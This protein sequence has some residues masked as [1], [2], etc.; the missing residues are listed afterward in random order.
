MAKQ[1]V[2]CVKHRVV[3][4][5]AILVI[6]VIIV[7]GIAIMSKWSEPFDT[8]WLVLFIV[9][10]LIGI[11]LTFVHMLLLSNEIKELLVDLALI[12][13]IFAA[14]FTINV[15]KTVPTVKEPIIII[16]ANGSWMSENPFQPEIINGQI[17]VSTEYPDGIVM[18]YRYDN[19][20]FIELEVKKNQVIIPL[21]CKDGQ[22][23][24]IS[25]IAVE[26]KEG[27]ER[28]VKTKTAY[29]STEWLRLLTMNGDFMNP[30]SVTVIEDNRLVYYI[31]LE[32]EQE[33]EQV[34]CNVSR[35]DGELQADITPITVGTYYRYNDLDDLYYGILEIPDEYLDGS[36][37]FLDFY[38]VIEIEGKS[39]RAPTFSYSFRAKDAERPKLE[40]SSPSSNTVTNGGTV[41]FVVKAIDN[42]LINYFNIK[43]GN[44][45]LNGFTADVSITGTGYERLITLSNIQGP[46][47]GNKHITIGAGVALDNDNNASERVA[48]TAFEIIK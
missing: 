12:A 44:I 22:R 6:S 30:G 24:S 32:M 9:A 10:S 27:L 11:L 1:F 21:K 16:E 13:G 4:I 40:I 17:V 7:Y 19:D 29:Y 38:A 8:V 3:S 48:G 15:I 47:G 35:L 5:I 26:S 43:A 37:Y 42:N 41:V 33:I 39:E 28:I 18:K 2:K 31:Y 20:D 23:H 36:I 14:F 46:T 45:I 25:V 34:L